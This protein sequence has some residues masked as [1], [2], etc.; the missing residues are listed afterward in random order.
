MALLESNDAR[1]EALE[2][3]AVDADWLLPLGRLG[4]VAKGIVYGLVGILAIPIAFSSGGGSEGEASRSGAIAEIAE[5][6]YGTIALWVL[7][8][9]LVLY[10][11]WR[12]VTA[13]LPADNDLD[14]LAHRVAYLSSAV[15]NG[16]LAWTAISFTTGSSGS[17]G[18][19]GDGGGGGLESLSRTLMEQ[20]AG[21]WLLGAVGL[22]GGRGGWLLRL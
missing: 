13:F 14:A 20:T 17:G 8:I 6:S 22:G 7:A 12:L 9:G 4:W 3:R 1:V 16:F 10:A 19:S 11:L 18:D 2:A 15:F 21:R 5:A